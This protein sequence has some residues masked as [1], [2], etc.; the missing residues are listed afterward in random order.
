[1]IWWMAW[2]LAEPTLEETPPPPVPDVVESLGGGVTI[3]WTTMSL[4]V[5]AEAHGRG[6]DSSQKTVEQQ[7]RSLAEPAL[8]A[9]IGQVQVDAQN[10]CGDLME[11]KAYRL[12][13]QA[14]LARWSVVEA[15]YYSSGKIEID[16]ELPLR[17]VLI[18]WTIEHAKA[19]PPLGEK[20]DTTG[21]VVD[22]RG[23]GV[24]PA[25]SPKLLSEKGEVLYDGGL[26]V[27]VG[28][29]ALPVVYVSSE[30]HPA[31]S[32][33]G[34]HPLS[35]KAASARGVDLVLADGDVRRFQQEFKGTR[36]LG[37]GRVILVVDPENL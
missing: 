5:S 25:F 34:E 1:M 21:V 8:S 28:H 19:P 6:V 11:E 37:E 14:R 35:L 27:D 29:T 15:R 33:A 7:A 18:P 20:P 22:A 32:R 12:P 17:E 36:L 26:W 13:I 2:A 23:L 3:N 16:G 4:R 9:A 30:L 31:V 10:T 24:K